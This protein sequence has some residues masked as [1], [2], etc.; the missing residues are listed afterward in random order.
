MGTKKGMKTLFEGTKEEIAHSRRILKLCLDQGESES[1]D[2]GPWFGTCPQRVL[3]L[4]HRVY[5]RE[6]YFISTT[7]KQGDS[8]FDKVCPSDEDDSAF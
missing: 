7:C 3:Q 1:R 6:W 4:E 2:A 8:L 5:G